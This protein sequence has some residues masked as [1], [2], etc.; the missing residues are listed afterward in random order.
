MEKATDLD[1]YE[2]LMARTALAADQNEALVGT[3]EV[4]VDV[5]GASVSAKQTTYR[6]R[7]GKRRATMRTLESASFAWG[8]VDGDGLYD[9]YFVN[10]VGGNELW[11]NL[12]NGKF[13]NITQEAGVALPG[14]VGVGA[15]KQCGGGGDGLYGGG[16]G[17]G[18]GGGNDAARAAEGLWE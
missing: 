16:A 8:D 7:V 17:S 15:G 14:R 1:A 9:I 12:G 13:K 6:V 2:S 11:K 18:G 10:Q 5:G 4:S 3:E